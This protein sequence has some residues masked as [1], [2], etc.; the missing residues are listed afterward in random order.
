MNPKD[1]CKDCPRGCNAGAEFVRTPEI[2]H[3]GKMVCP[4]CGRFLDWVKKPV[5]TERRVVSGYPYER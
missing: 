4:K 1:K 3:Y 2:I 5:N